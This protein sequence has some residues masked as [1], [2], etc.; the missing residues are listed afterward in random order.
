MLEDPPETKYQEVIAKIEYEVVE[1]RSDY[2][3]ASNDNAILNHQMSEMKNEDAKLRQEMK[4]IRINMN[5]IT[6]HS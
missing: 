1:I 4:K 5:L 2:L 6:L 3:R